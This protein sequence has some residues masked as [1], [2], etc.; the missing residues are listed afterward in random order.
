MIKEHDQVVLLHDIFEKD[1]KRDDIGTVIHIY[2]KTEAFEVEFT[3]L[4]GQTIAVAT[5]K[6][7]E[8]RETDSRDIPHARILAAK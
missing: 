2:P 8:I 1:L 4:G 5:L 6:S 7:S 3:T